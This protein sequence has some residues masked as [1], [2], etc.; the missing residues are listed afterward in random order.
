MSSPTNPKVEKSPYQADMKA[1]LFSNPDNEH[2]QSSVTTNN[3][4]HPGNNASFSI[5]ASTPKTDRGTM[6]GKYASANRFSHLMREDAGGLYNSDQMGTEQSQVNEKKCKAEKPLHKRQTNAQKVNNLN[7]AI[8]ARRFRKTRIKVVH[9]FCEQCTTFYAME[10]VC[11][12]N[13]PSS[14]DITV[15]NCNEH[16]N[17]TETVFLSEDASP[18]NCV[19]VKLPNKTTKLFLVDSGASASVLPDH[20]VNELKNYIQEIPD[21]LPR[22]VQTASRREKVEAEYYMSF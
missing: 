6:D 16:N 9:L 14:E 17:A 19:N 4:S 8:N 18:T 13:D 5:T 3:E 22:Y 21:C 12:K 7:R 11:D 10:K 20:T 1:N 15:F 2:T